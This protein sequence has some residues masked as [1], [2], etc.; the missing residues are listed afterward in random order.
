MLELL[1]S[2]YPSASPVTGPPP[3]LLYDPVVGKDIIGNNITEVITGTGVTVNSGRLLNGFGV[4]EFAA[5]GNGQVK[6][7]FTTPLNFDNGDWTIEYDSIVDTFP[8]TGNYTNGFYLYGSTANQYI[9]SMFGNFGEGLQAEFFKATHVNGNYSNTWRYGLNRIN[10]QGVVRRTAI[11]K[12]G[13][14]INVYYN[15]SRVQ[16]QN[17]LSG[18]GGTTTENIPNVATGLFPF[19]LLGYINSS[20]PSFKGAFGRFAVYNYARY[21]TSGYPVRPITT[22]GS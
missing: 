21:T 5:A 3:T 2:G 16:V 1:L 17:L 9:F 4:K 11:V 14:V 6:V 7:N 12:K 15:G 8:A 22:S 20:F 18:Q 19:M 13:S 10:Y